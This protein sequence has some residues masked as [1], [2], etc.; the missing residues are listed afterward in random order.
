MATRTPE[1]HARISAF[2]AIE[3]LLH[4]L[5]QYRGRVE[6]GECCRLVER[7]HARE[8]GRLMIEIAIEAPL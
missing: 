5:D 1:D 6:S 3:D 7:E 8:P 2:R 4:L